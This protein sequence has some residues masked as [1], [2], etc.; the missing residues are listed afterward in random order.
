[1]SN[2]IKI[3]NLK[4]SYSDGSSFGMNIKSFALKKGERLLIHGNLA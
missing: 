3:D 2:L 4:Y 1:M